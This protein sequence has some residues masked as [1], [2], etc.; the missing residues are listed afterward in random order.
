MATFDFSQ[1]FFYKWRYII[2]YS[3]V[4]LLLA[5]VL[6]FAGLYVPGG[7]SEN[8][9]A[10]VVKSQ[11]LAYGD[12]G[13]LTIVNL[14]FHALQDG[15]LH[16]F[17][18]SIFTIKLPSLI[19]AL[20]SAIGLIALLR[21]W[22]KPNIAILA[23]LIAIS[24]GQFLYIAQ[25]GT[26][27]ILYI[28]WPVMILLLG[29]QITR[30]KRLRLL[31][32]VLFGITIALSLYTPLGIYMVFAV[33]LTVSLH[34]HLRA[35]IRRLS[36]LKLALTLGATLLVI[37]PL[38]MGVVLS[39]AVALELLGL[40]GQWPSITEH[41][42]LLATQYFVFWQT[43]A[44]H[45]ITPVF[46]LGSSLLVI[47]GLYRLIRTFDTTRSYLIVIWIVSLTPVLILNPT[48]TS[49]TFL[50]T[51]LLLAAGLT[52]LIGYWY[53]LFPHNPYARVA[54]L[55]PII[56][57]V[58]ALIGSGVTRYV[59]GYHYSPL[60]TSL[61]SKDLS[62]IPES[63][64]EL[65]VSEDKKPFYTA[66]AQYEDTFTVVDTPTQERVVV[67]R[68]AET[69]TKGYEVVRIITSTRSDNADRFYVYQKQD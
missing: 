68:G 69:D 33:A 5:A 13:L 47:L 53:R 40:P 61:F 4:A 58:V 20:F 18:A 6:I 36:K 59:Y 25:L 45:L 14:P 9:M 30:K 7:L 67:S 57:L 17:G 28:F 46:G 16:V 52:S 44:T 38:I 54:G 15:I 35:A 39:P 34:P 12:I 2:G 56:I 19:L 50:P 66:V 49:T 27:E 60:A 32:K 65:I 22:F 37:A 1:Y 29:T 42:S 62:L 24:T 23:S 8:E 3:S 21:R 26:P 51:V 11:Q 48:L 63:T 64:G 55:F 43:D 10:S 31:W 41:L